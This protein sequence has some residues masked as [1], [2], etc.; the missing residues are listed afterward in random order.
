MCGCRAVY[1]TAVLRS[2]AV[3]RCARRAS[4]GREQHAQRAA[5]DRSRRRA[6]WRKDLSRPNRRP[7]RLHVTL[8]GAYDVQTESCDRSADTDMW[9]LLE[10]SWCSCSPRTHVRAW[11]L[12]PVDLG[13]WKLSRY[14]SGGIRLPR[15]LENQK[16]KVM[17]G[18]ARLQRL[19]R[20][21]CN[22]DRALLSETAGCMLRGCP[23]A[24]RSSH[25]NDH[26]EV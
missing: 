15:K 7:F 5:Y 3:M 4:A 13:P 18:L 11:M 17:A 9:D 22:N 8:R 1:K 16:D 14:C 23:G 12:E 20:K 24:M 25:V 2:V 6:R 21:P 26:G 19:S 10:R